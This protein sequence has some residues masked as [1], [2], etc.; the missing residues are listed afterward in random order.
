M[1]STHRSNYLGQVTTFYCGSVQIGHVITTGQGC[2]LDVH[3]AR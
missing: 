2:A 3:P 1:D